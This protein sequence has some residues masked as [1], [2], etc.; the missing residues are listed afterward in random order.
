[1]SE[2]QPKQ[3]A[4]R[5]REWKNEADMRCKWVVLPGMYCKLPGDGHLHTCNQKDC[6]FYTPRH[7]VVAEP[8]RLEIAAQI[9]GG[10]WATRTDSH[11]WL[12]TPERK[13]LETADVL[14]AA[15]AKK[16]D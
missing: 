12:K 15:C 16:E 11:E 13:A 1:M 3:G 6:K 4:S 8:S 5:G 10:M 14:I 2:T 9:L 7:P